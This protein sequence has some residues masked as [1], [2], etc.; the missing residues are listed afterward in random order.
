M[1]YASG[2]SPYDFE[3]P[4]TCESVAEVTTPVLNSAKI[5]LISLDWRTAQVGSTS[6]GITGASDDDS[7]SLIKLMAVSKRNK[8]FLHL[9]CS[10]ATAP[11]F[12]SLLLLIQQERVTIYQLQQHASYY[13]I[14]LL[15]NLMT[16]IKQQKK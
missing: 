2:V 12:S 4:K 15:T 8:I 1:N 16:Y 7:I 13:T 5:N 14:V 10:G 6:L 9:L 3:L 11:L